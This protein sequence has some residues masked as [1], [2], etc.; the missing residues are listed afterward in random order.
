M[1]KGY[2]MR[3]KKAV[4]F[5]KQMRTRFAYQKLSYCLKCNTYTAFQDDSCLECGSN[6]LQNLDKHIEIITKRRF[7]IDQI[8]ILTLFFSGIFFSKNLM[9]LGLIFLFSIIVF[10]FTIFLQRKNILTERSNNLLILVKKQRKHIKE[11]L[12]RNFNVALV[13]IKEQNFKKAY[14]QLRD[15]GTLII[16]D[17]KKIQKLICLDQFLLRKDMELE[18]DSLIISSYNLGLVYYIFEIA[19][20]NRSLIK[21]KT[22]D[23]IVKY[24]QKI[25]EL[26]NGYEILASVAGA[27]PRTKQHVISYKDFLIKYIRYLKHDRLLRLCKLIK[28]YYNDEWEDIRSETIRVIHDNFEN[29]LDLRQFI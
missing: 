23:Y 7:Q 29:D 14:E 3:I 19:K 9:E 24:E 22:I 25:L 5:K 27:I 4:Q 28:N 11:G 26:E 18:S 16:D 15:I 20:V 13:N 21:K 10:L 2:N 8:L 1:N 17:N 12:N 6:R